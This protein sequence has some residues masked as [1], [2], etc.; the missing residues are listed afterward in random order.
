MEQGVFLSYRR[1]DTAGH[2]GR[3]CDELER[4]FDYPIVFRDV[5]SISAGSDFVTALER[6][7]ARARVALVLIGDTWL[8]STAADGRRR[9][10][11][12]EDHVRRE[13][14]LA[15]ERPGMTVL[16]VLLEGAAMPGEPD[17]PAPLRRLARLQAI[18]LSERRWDHDMARL[19]KV[20]KG[21][22]VAPP[23]RLL[24]PTW[25]VVVIGLLLAALLGMA[26]WCWQGAGTGADRYTGIWYL[27]DGGFWTVQERDGELW[28]EETHHE[29]RQVWKR[30]PG[31]VGGDGLVASL[32]LVFGRQPFRYEHRLRLSRDGRALLGTVSRS[33][34]ERESSTVLM[35]DRQ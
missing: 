3:I 19:V 5:D 23:R 4:R 6:A 13:I 31:L 21:A 35:R 27:P 1:A 11:D 17:L 10:D 34:S 32:E 7:I 33:D 24:P 26:V 9:L 28:V 29:S 15:L 14:A 12:P 8:S 16:P 18:E 25:A 22:G 30:G 20:L 2:A